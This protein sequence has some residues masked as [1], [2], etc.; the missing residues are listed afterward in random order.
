MRRHNLKVGERVIMHGTGFLG[1]VI[2]DKEAW[3]EIKL[4][5]ELE[6]VQVYHFNAWALCSRHKPLTTWT[7][8]GCRAILP[9]PDKGICDPCKAYETADP[10]HQGD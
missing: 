9:L 7:C 1:T 8:P 4:D 10:N 6:P 3:L 2:A 5:F